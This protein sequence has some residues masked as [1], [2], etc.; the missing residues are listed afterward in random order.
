[1]ALLSLRLTFLPLLVLSTSPTHGL[2]VNTP[3]MGFSHWAIETCNATMP[4]A[5]FFQSTADAF[6]RLGLRD[7]GYEYL[8][9]DDCWMLPQRGSA[10][11]Q[12]VD[13]SKF[14]D[15]MQSLADYVHARGLKLGI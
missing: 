10:G 2:V 13:P 5:A 4:S 3:P 1:M 11:Q 12:L 7:A 8:Q 14:P 15:G 9:I 6:V